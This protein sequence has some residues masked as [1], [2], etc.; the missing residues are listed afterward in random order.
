MTLKNIKILVNK[1]KERIIKY[2]REKKIEFYLCRICSD[3]VERNHFDSEEHIEKFHKVCKIETKESLENSFITI[4]YK[5]IE[6]RYN[7]IY[8]DLYFKKYTV[9]AHMLVTKFFSRAILVY[10]PL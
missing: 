1:L 8:S 10:F 4:K 7:Y 9:A 3:I 5:F 6:T 2:S